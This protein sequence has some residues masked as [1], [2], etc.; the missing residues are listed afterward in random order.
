MIQLKTLNKRIATSSKGV[1]YF[2]FDEDGRAKLKLKLLSHE[3]Y[4]EYEVNR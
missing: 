2:Y 1:Y 4:N 3:G